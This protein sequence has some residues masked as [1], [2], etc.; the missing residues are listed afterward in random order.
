[1]QII[2]EESTGWLTI[3]FK[4]RDGDPSIPVS[5]F[6]RIDTDQG[7]QLRDW[8]EIADQVT[9]YELQLNPSDNKIIDEET[10]MQVNIVTVIAKFGDND[11]RTA[12]YR[13]RVQNFAQIP[14]VNG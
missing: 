8:E 5:F 12:E 6:I 1:M 13:Y 7:E 2:N 10:S 11:Q 3:E 4:D 9:E 14:K